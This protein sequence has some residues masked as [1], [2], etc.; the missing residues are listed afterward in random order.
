MKKDD[1]L[2]SPRLAHAIAEYPG[3]LYPPT[4]VAMN[5]R[6]FQRLLD[7]LRSRENF[8]VKDPFFFAYFV[9]DRIAASFDFNAEIALVVTRPGERVRNAGFPFR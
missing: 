8:E 9:C 6:R 5:V 3:F 4:R 7:R 2:F 1:P